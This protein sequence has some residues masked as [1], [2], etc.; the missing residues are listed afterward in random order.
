MCK[1]LRQ[2]LIR[3]NRKRFGIDSW[4]QGIVDRLLNDVFPPHV[5]Y[6]YDSA[7]SFLQRS[8]NFTR[9]AIRVTLFFP[10]YPLAID[11]VGI[12]G[13]ENYLEASPYIS[14]DGWET[15]QADL[16][17][18]RTEL[19]KRRCPYLLITDTE[20]ADVDTLRSNV[21]ILTGTNLKS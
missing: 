6:Y 12:D 7:F 15:L 21:K 2:W 18:K 1:L 17:L 20:P 3:R 19:S 11:V 5:P 14:K 13:R 10:N 16:A 8:R 9:S 4:K